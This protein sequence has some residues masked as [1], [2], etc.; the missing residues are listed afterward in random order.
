MNSAEVI[1]ERG[2]L[3]EFFSRAVRAAYTAS[4]FVGAAGSSTP[5]IKRSFETA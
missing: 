5:A 3:F 1:W 2:Q 4:R